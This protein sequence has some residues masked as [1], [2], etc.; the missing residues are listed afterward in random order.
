MSAKSTVD[1]QATIRLTAHPLQRIGA[2]A[3]ARLAD[4]ADPSTLDEAAFQIAV[5]RMTEHA[6]EAAVG[7]DTKAPKGFFLKSSLSLFPNAPMFHPSNA[8]RSDPE[9]RERVLAWRRRPDPDAWLGVP[10]VLCSA[11]AVGFF[12]KMDVPLAESDAYRN[13]TPRRHAGM[14][15]CWPCLCCFYALPYGSHLTGGPSLALH[16]WDEAFLARTIA[17]Q[18]TR[19]R[20]V[21]AAGST[22]REELR[23]REVLALKYLRHYDKSLTDGVQLLVYSNNNRGPTI[24]TYAVDQA[25]AEWLRSVMHHARF[26]AGFRALLTAHRTTDLPGYV[27]LARNAFRSPWRIPGACARYLSRVAFTQA[28]PDDRR[29]HDV[30]NLA[31]LCFNYADK[32][33]RM[34]KGDLEEIRATAKRFAALLARETTAGKLREFYTLFSKPTR[35][36]SRL[37]RSAVEWILVA[38]D[39]QEGPLLTTRGFGL[40]FDPDYDNQAWF[41]RQMFLV[42]VVEELHGLGWKPLSSDEGEQTAQDLP[43]LND[44]PGQEDNDFAMGDGKGAL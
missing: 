10:C 21:I 20:Q 4:G 23:A 31:G 32:V 28:R 19:T 29:W 22:A 33:M 13:N 30:A 6:I 41:H 38:P 42:A 11:T 16:S 27:G 12:G 1:E 3:L 5:D 24:D 43:E 40:L 34:D 18:V 15:L 39:G 26:Q 17:I 7:R 9:I 36:R 8:R 37:Q 14:A 44:D 2:Y 35:L 25:L